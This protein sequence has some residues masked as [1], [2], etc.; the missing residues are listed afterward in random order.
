[1]RQEKGLRRR[2][3]PFLARICSVIVVAGVVMVVAV[4][5]AAAAAAIFLDETA[6]EGHANHRENKP[7]CK[8]LHCLLRCSCV[9]A[10]RKQ[11]QPANPPWRRAS[12]D[13]GG[14]QRS[15]HG[16]KGV[17]T[18]TRREFGRDATITAIPPSRR[19]PHGVAG[20][21]LGAERA[22]S[23]PSPR[24]LRGRPSPAMREREGPG[25]QRR[26]G[27]GR[28]GRGFILVCALE[29]ARDNAAR[30]ASLIAASA[31]GFSSSLAVA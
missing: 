3:Q 13:R 16:A 7:R 28:S 25:A 22:V 29:P 10:P 5:V 4:A 11:P 18:A 23:V 17:A 9:R 31:A 19:D 21:P 1:R 24:P 20:D 30:Y 14:R 2:P 15:P 12:R 26:E 8:S 27:E 6:G